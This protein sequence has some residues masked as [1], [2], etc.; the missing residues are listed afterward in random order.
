MK[1]SEFVLE[2]FPEIDYESTEGRAILKW[3]YMWVDI[4]IF[5]YGHTWHPCAY[6]K[7]NK[8]PDDI[9]YLD[10]PCH[11]WITFNNEVKEDSAWNKWRFKPW[12]WIGWDYA[13]CDDYMRLLWRWKKW[14]TNEIMEEIRD[15][16]IRCSKNWLI[17]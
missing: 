6:V 5:F 3:K 12:L 7:V 10:V 14:T 1:K 17:D 4:M 16:I 11:W 13:H 2:E 15:V 9:E 8:I